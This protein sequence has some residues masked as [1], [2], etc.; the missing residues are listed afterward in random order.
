MEKS[1]VRHLSET[2]LTIDQPD[3]GYR[4]SEDPFILAGHVRFG[5][6]E[7]ILDIGTGCGVIPL[8][9]ASR[10]KELSIFGVEIQEELC[11]FAVR[12][13][14]RNGFKDRVHIIQKDIA[15]IEIE[16]IDGPVDIIVSNPPYKRRGTGRLNPDSQ[17]ALARHEIS[18]DIEN[19]F[20]CASRLL[21]NNGRLYIIFP[22]D[23]IH[24]LMVSMEKYHFSASGI[25]FVHTKK[26]VPAK[27]VLLDAVKNRTVSC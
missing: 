22:A 4:F 6:M 27:R 1:T 14:R 16:E 23:R 7:T 21:K 15:D 24:D 25:R 12:N 11:D 18:L 8:L 13:I 20:R 2:D 9:L 3:S 5:G 26:N 17:K 19:V 10:G